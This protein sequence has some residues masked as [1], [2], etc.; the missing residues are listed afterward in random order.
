VADDLGEGESPEAVDRAF[1]RALATVA[2]HAVVR[3]GQRLD[4]TQVDALLEQMGDTPGSGTCPHGRPVAIR[5]P[6]G[7]LERRFRRS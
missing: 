1:H 7:E 3:A 4:R 6:R 5:F 2:C